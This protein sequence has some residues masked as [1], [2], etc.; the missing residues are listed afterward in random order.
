MQVTQGK[1]NRE[2]TTTVICNNSQL[3]SILHCPSL[4]CR[5]N[6]E[7][8]PDI[9]KGH[10]NNA[11][12]MRFYLCNI[13]FITLFFITLWPHYSQNRVKISFSP[14]HLLA[15]HDDV[16]F[17]LTLPF[18]WCLLHTSFGWKCCI[19]VGVIS[20][21]ISTFPPQILNVFSTLKFSNYGISYS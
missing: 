2:W 4:V 6:R 8:V 7:W 12:M 18:C 9:T 1:G 5:C 3:D 19:W 15:K 11:M 16:A 13:F 20:S 17:W 21:V 14:I 10:W